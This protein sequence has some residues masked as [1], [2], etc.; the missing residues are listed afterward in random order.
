MPHQKEKMTLEFFH[1]MFMNARG[2]HPGRKGTVVP[3]RGSGSL[4][5]SRGER[6]PLFVK[7]YCKTCFN[8]KN[9]CRCNEHDD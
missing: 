7:R 6:S 4:S 2:D 3:R 1:S 5:K 9:M 8:R